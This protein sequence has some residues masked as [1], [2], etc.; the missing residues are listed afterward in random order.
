MTFCIA[1]VGVELQ[2]A[3]EG[4]FEY[5]TSQGGQTADNTVVVGQKVHAKV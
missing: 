4:D 3:G 2:F 1:Y 5:K